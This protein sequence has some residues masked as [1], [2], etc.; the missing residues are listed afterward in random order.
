MRLQSDRRRLALDGL[1]IAGA[2]A[3]LWYVLGPIGLGVAGVVAVT[4]VV[5]SPV[6]AFA[7]GQL[8]F[9][10]LAAALYG[11]VPATGVLVAEAGLA[12]ILVAA[13]LDH[14]PRWSAAVAVGVFAVAAVGFG[15]ASALEPL[16]HGAAVVAVIYA[17]LAYTL[18]RYELV[19]L[20][21]VGEA[22]R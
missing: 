1:A 18:H 15:S 3:A 10:L 6:Y 20:G 22:D 4:L 16:W 19:S 5:V 12:A 13:L 21:L 17:G 11:E 8:L 2:T 14:W 9:V 7:V